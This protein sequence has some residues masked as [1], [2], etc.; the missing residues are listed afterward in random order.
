MSRV[1]VIVPAI[2]ST[3]NKDIALLSLQGEVNAEILRAICDGE[4]LAHY[5]A[6]GY[7]N[8]NHG[9]L[10]WALFILDTKSRF[11][12]QRNDLFYFDFVLNPGKLKTDF[13]LRSWLRC[14]QSQDQLC[15]R[16][17]YSQT[18]SLF[19]PL[20]ETE[21]LQEYIS[22]LERANEQWGDS[23]NYLLALQSLP[24]RGLIEQGIKHI[25]TNCRSSSTQQRLLINFAQSCK[26]DLPLNHKLH[27]LAKQESLRPLN[28]FLESQLTKLPSGVALNQLLANNSPDPSENLVRDFLFARACLQLSEEQNVPMIAVGLTD[29]GKWC[30]RKNPFE[31]DVDIL[32]QFSRAYRVLLSETHW[33]YLIDPLDIPLL[34][35]NFLNMQ[36]LASVPDR[37]Q[38]RETNNILK[39]AILQKQYSISSRSTVI[40]GKKGFNSVTFYP[41]EEK[42][43]QCLF[44]IILQANNRGGYNR[45]LFGRLDAALGTIEA[46]GMTDNPQTQKLIH[47]LL[48][49]TTL[50]YR[51]LL[52][53]RQH[54]EMSEYKTTQKQ[55]KS[56]PSRSSN[57]PLLA[58]LKRT[59]K[60]LSEQFADPHILVEQL[61]KI[62]PQM[63][64]EHLRNLPS[65]YKPL[66]REKK[67]AQSYGFL[68]PEGFTF[69]CPTLIE[70]EGIEQEK[71]NKYFCSL[72]LLQL[73]FS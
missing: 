45:C 53:A 16:I 43:H 18:E 57:F 27:S 1:P 21:Q 55:H 9:S 20:L 44:K 36:E 46:V 33:Q 4:E 31:G 48:F 39:L 26:W 54:M 11:Y 17:P 34:N 8:T 72:S 23:D 14:L 19:T 68:L 12:D 32:W 29:T 60:E 63:R 13:T 58:R 67:F 69:I 70:E 6:T 3:P 35:V 42:S 73:L 62:A 71:L 64:V 24:L 28:Q 22:L 5:S 10:T 65:D 49:L 50:A 37:K 66:E 40:L 15:I 30:W 61:R 52:V 56:K 2:S 47:L 38:F 51:D 59:S 25:N 7:S 41:L